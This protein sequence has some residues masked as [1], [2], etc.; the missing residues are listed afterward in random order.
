MPASLDRTAASPPVLPAPFGAGISP[1][2]AGFH[3]PTPYSKSSM[4]K[5]PAANVPVPVS[6]TYTVFALV[7]IGI[8]PMRE[9]AMVG[10]N[11][12][13]MVQLAP[14]GSAG[15]KQLLVCAKSLESGIVI[16]PTVSGCV[17]VF[18]SVT[19]CAADV[20]PRTWFPK[21]S[22]VG[23]AVAAGAGGAAPVPDSATV[24]GVPD[25]S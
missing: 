2:S 19:D 8:V 10:V 9:P 13:L 5:V 6:W 17:P 7:E 21:P 18:V 22:D 14:G 16:P 4:K 3:A 23:E 15:P 25:A 1:L 11:V 12:T 20:T 24:C